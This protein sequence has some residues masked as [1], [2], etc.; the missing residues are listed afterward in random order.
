MKIK[1]SYTEFNVIIDSIIMQYINENCL[2]SPM[3]AYLLQKSSELKEKYCNW[4]TNGVSLEECTIRLKSE[5]LPTARRSS[6]VDELPQKKTD[7][8]KYQWYEP[9]KHLSGRLVF[10]ICNDEQ[11]YYLLPLIKMNNRPIVLFLEPGVNNNLSVESNIVAVKISAISDL[12][13]YDDRFLESYFPEVYKYY[14]TFNF[15]MEILSPEGIVF[16]ESS[17]FQ[18]Q[19]LSLIAQKKEIPCLAIQQKWT[20]AICRSHQKEFYQYLLTWGDN[21]NEEW[22]KM[23]AKTK[24]ISTGYIHSIE[25]N[26]KQNSILFFVED[27]ISISPE[28]C[29]DDFIKIIYKTAK[30]Y[31]Q[32][33]VLVFESSGGILSEVILEKIKQYENIHFVS[34]VP[35]SEVLTQAQLMISF[36]CSELLESIAYNCIPIAFDSIPN[37]PCYPLNIETFEIRKVAFNGEDFFQKLD[38]IINSLPIFLEKIIDEKEKWFCAVGNNALKKTS[39]CINQIACCHYLKKN[40]E[41]RLHIGCGSYPIEGWLNV[42]IGDY[43]RTYYL[44]AGRPYPFPDNSFNYIFSEHLFEHLSLQQGITMLEEC[45]RILKIG[46]KKRM[47]MP[48]FDFLINLYLHPEKEIHQRYLSWCTPL[49][50]PEIKEYYKNEEYPPIYA[51]NNFCHAWGH[52]FIH[53]FEELKTLATKIGFKKIKRGSIGK[54]ET[55]VFQSIERHGKSIPSWAN[56]LETV[57]VE[58]EK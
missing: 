18:Q 56:E 10:Y 43:P 46:G 29:L 16:A 42:D 17:Y 50:V 7:F 31:P 39:D 34:G 47:A 24:C 40:K 22:N 44:D 4:R 51:F 12:K 54:S 35:L 19:I 48:D 25:F 30:R 26:K 38:S 14:N 37:A 23:G 11:L 15:L 52:Q 53:S 8:T 6:R 20:L 36:Y 41:P 33:E 45:Y 3:Y 5:L 28:I 55:P 32:T 2:E 13:L 49:F 9:L 21:F 58:M 27:P 1:K 57:V